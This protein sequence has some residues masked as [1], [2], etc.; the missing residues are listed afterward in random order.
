MY[1]FER[2][3]TV[4]TAGDLPAALKFASEVT[5]YLNQRHSLNMKCGAE[6]FGGASIHWYFDANSLD[7]MTEVN[8]ALLKDREYLGMLDKVKGVWAEGSMKDTIVGLA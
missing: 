7:K 4:K 1:R 2:S 3:A 6:I 8:E 5:S